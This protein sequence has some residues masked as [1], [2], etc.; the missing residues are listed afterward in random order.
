MTN[1]AD[2]ASTLPGMELPG[3]PEVG[4]D[5]SVYEATRRQLQQ[6]AKLGYI[7]EHH[8][9]KVQLALAA[10]RDIDRSQGRG[11]PSGRANLYR[12]MNEILETIP[13]PEAASKDALDAT[14][15]AMMHDDEADEVI[16]YG[17]A[18]RSEA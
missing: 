12:V 5:E 10:A 2:A 6:L 17:D 3:V 15:Q 16:V 14:L 18:V 13:Q 9:G 8:A 7:E 11:A 4:S 1:P